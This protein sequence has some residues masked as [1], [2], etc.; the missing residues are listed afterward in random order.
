[1]NNT[2]WHT[3]INTL[4]TD[5]ALEF[6]DERPNPDQE[7]IDVFT[8]L[9]LTNDTPIEV[10]TDALLNEHWM[11][12]TISRTP[13]HVVDAINQCYG[14]NFKSGTVYEQDPDRLLRYAKMNGITAK[15]SVM[16]NGEIIFGVGRLIAAL[17]RGD[18]SIK[19]W[20]LKN[21]L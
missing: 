1:M 20:S 8:T 12:G 15:P 4:P 5:L 18:A 7:D 13:K 16:V 2:Q 21:E 11:R 14:T 10:S 17:L 3:W 9:H 19:V 6:I